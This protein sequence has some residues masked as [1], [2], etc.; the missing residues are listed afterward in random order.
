MNIIRE[1]L[2]EW[3]KSEER[4]AD[5][6]KGVELLERSG[7]L[8]LLMRLGIPNLIAHGSDLNIMA[9]QASWSNGYQTCLEQLKY[10]IRMFQPKDEGVQRAMGEPDFG[11]IQRALRQGDIRKEDLT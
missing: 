9:S 4:I 6:L 7:A 1:E 11:G 3:F 2:D 8:K 10:F 5:Y